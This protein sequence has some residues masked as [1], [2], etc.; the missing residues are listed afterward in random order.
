MDNNGKAAKTLKSREFTGAA[1]NS[2]HK[3]DEVE[4][5]SKLYYYPKES[6]SFGGV[7]RLSED[8]SLK[9]SRVRKFLSREDPYSLQFPVRYKF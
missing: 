3:M 4:R 8:S 7:K 6:C 5:L 2:A 9:K 1:R